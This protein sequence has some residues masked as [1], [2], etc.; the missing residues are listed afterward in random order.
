MILRKRAEEILNLVQKTEKEITLSDQVVVGDVYIG[1]GETDAVRLIARAAHSLYE[2]YPGIHYHIASGNA[3]F[4]L[5]QLEKG[6]IDFG[7][8]FDTI[9][10]NKYNE[11]KIPYKDIWG[12]LMRQDSPLPKKKPSLRKICWTNL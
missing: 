12:V 9:D 4:V 6:L 11:I 10:Q 8:I 3:E 1:T 5:E 7:I 2:V